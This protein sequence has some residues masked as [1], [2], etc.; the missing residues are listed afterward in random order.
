MDW[1]VLKSDSNFKVQ[2]FNVIAKYL[3]KYQRNISLD[4]IRYLHCRLFGRLILSVL[5]N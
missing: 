5:N 1:G 3:K 4:N 2:T